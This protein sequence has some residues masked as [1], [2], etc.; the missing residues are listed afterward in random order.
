MA[1]LVIRVVV[2][3][4]VGVV[5]VVGKV[6]GAVLV[7]GKVVGAV[8]VVGEV[9][10]TVLVVGEVGNGAGCWRDGWSG[11]AWLERCWLLGRCWSTF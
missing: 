2:G 3:E 1:V 6:I 8:L 9:V 4:V 10:G 7:V 11:A 5:L